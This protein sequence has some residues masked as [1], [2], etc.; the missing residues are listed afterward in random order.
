MGL[1]S[2]LKNM[3]LHGDGDSYM[4]VVAEVTLPPLKIV[5]EDWRGG[6]MVG[7]VAVDL[8]LDKLEMEFVAGGLLVPAIRKFGAAA[9]DG[10]MLRF[11]GAYQA[12]DGSAVKAVEVVSR[13]R[14]VEIDMGGAK[15]GDDTEHTFKSVLSYYKLS[16][17]GRTEIE[18]DMVGGVFIV[19]GI[20]RNAEIRAALG[21]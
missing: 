4:G 5:T 21:A 1:P 7:A 19:D 9:H 17:D 3:N 8:G 2:K 20:D 14:Y 11:N 13:G 18:I 15:P 10:T 12:D 6:G 16:I